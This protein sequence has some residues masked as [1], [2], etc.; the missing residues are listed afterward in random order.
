MLPGHGAN[1][2]MNMIFI[3]LARKRTKRVLADIRKCCDN[4]VFVV[5]SEVSKFAGGYGLVK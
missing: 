5:A 4:K 1:E 3:V 2:K